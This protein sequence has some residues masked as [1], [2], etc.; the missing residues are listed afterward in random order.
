MRKNDK[1]FG[2]VPV[3]K[4]NNKYFFLLIQHD[5]GHWAFPKGHPKTGETEIQTAFRE[6]KEETGIKDCS[7]KENIFFRECYSYKEKSQTINKTVKYF[8]GFIGIS[9]NIKIK[10]G[11]IQNYKWA[12]F[13]EALNLITFK[14]A[15]KILKQVKNYLL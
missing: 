10:K 6:L 5:A 7:I 9:P 1:S 8:L 14:E 3:S 12:S 4:R 15:R 11:E 2:V 13:E